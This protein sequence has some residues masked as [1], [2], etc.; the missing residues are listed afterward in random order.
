MP[1]LLLLFLRLIYPT[2]ISDLTDDSGL[3]FSGD[4]DDL[5]NK[6]TI[7]AD[8]NDLN[9]VDDKLH[10]PVKEVTSIPS[11]PTP[12]ANQCKNPTTCLDDTAKAYSRRLYA[13][14]SG[15]TCQLRIGLRVQ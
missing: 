2:D 13:R 14:W 11:T 10:G 3:L 5:S 8:L 12:I 9:D 7:P 1:P 15:W 6:P 4:Y